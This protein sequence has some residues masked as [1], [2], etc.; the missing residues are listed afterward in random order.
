M[1]RPERSG[2]GPASPLRRVRERVAE[3]SAAMPTESF[4]VTAE[5][6]GVITRAPAGEDSD[7]VDKFILVE[8]AMGWGSAFCPH[9]DRHLDGRAI[10]ADARTLRSGHVCVDIAALDAAAGALRM[11]PS[12]SV[13]ARGT[14]HRK[15]R[16]RA[17]LVAAEVDRVLSPRRPAR[18]L[19]VGVTA[20][21][22]EVL[23]ERG[24]SVLA[25]DLDPQ[26]VGADIHGVRVHHGTETPRLLAQADAAVVTGMTTTTETVGEVVTAADAGEVPLVF[27]AQ[28]GGRICPLLLDHCSGA[29]VAERFPYYML[30]GDTTFDI[31]RSGDGGDR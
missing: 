26:V 19:L 18:V 15:G 24:H 12:H 16:V 1:P 2:Q 4:T 20:A 7:Y 29:V 21:M 23:T 31:Y 13:T 11:E 8:T 9:H 27:F 5:T 6:R 17:E 22:V 28:T 25:S 30:S 3:F 10:G 14:T